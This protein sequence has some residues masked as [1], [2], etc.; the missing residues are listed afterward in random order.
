MAHFPRVLDNYLPNREII[1]K[2]QTRQKWQ[3]N[4]KKNITQMEN[5]IFYCDIQIIMG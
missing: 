3:S 2:K 5:L 1:K 4:C